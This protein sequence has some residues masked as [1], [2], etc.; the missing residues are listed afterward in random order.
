MRVI[1]RIEM[2]GASREARSRV[3]L[4]IPPYMVLPSTIRCAIARWRLAL[5]DRKSHLAVLKIFGD[6]DL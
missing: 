1:R 5:V 3:A 2:L 4:G 6:G